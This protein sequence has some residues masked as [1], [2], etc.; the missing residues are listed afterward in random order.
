MADPV[1][2]KLALLTAPHET[3]VGMV[4]EMLNIGTELVLG[5]RPNAHQQWLCSRLADLGY[6]VT[7]QVAV[8]DSG[9]I[10][11]RALADALAR[12]DLLIATGGLGPTSDD[13]TVGQV[14][15]LLGV[16]LREDKAVLQQIETFYAAHTRPMPELAKRQALVPEG[17]RVLPNAHG[18]APGVA[19]E[20]CPN[21]FRPDG[22]PTLLILLPGP[23][24]EL[25]P[26]FEQWVVPLLKERFKGSEPYICRTLR[27][28]GLAESLVQQKI[29]GPLAAL[30]AA[31]LELGYTATPW[32]VDIRLAARGS[33]A[34]DIVGKAEHTVRQLLGEAVF[35]EG[36]TA[37]ETVV[38]RLFS[39]RRL[40]LAIAESCTGGC[41]AH[42]VTNVPGAS[43]VFL[44]GFVTY[45]NTAKQQ[46]LGVE[47]G[48]IAEHGA[49]SDVVARQMA[50]GARRVSGADYAL[51]VTGIA[52]P[53]GGTLA[54]PVGTVY[55]ALATPTSLTVE[56]YF[57]PY[58]RRT[59]KQVTAQ[60]ALNMLRLALVRAA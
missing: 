45:S 43:A 39:E 17:A 20:L 13:L 23:A 41:I 42:K 5:Q 54:K 28:V 21:R 7:R 24:H 49:V 47:P 10:I 37:L 16:P 11:Q 48:A 9:E 4:V 33:A 19:I 25:R 22:K 50:A 52:G 3:C 6:P 31:G 12:A 27:T 32:N 14:A 46:F 38:V 2:C 26:M 53:T 56:R 57:N 60:Q 1:R 40:T 59:F 18:T 58:D 29:S 36:D 35:G 30:V 15:K 44:A 34:S 51:S 8:P 55:I